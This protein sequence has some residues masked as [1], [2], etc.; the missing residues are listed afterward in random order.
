MAI[1]KVTASSAN[2]AKNSFLFQL[3]GIVNQLVEY[4]SGDGM[5]TTAGL[6][7]DSTPEDVETNNAIFYRIG[8]EVYTAA[9]NGG[10]SFTAAHVVTAEKFGAIL[11]QID[12]A[13]SFSTKV[14]E[15]TQT[16]AMAYDTA[17]EA[18]A[19]LPAPDEGNVAVGHIVIEADSGNWVGN[20]DSMTD[21][22]E[23]ATFV[24]YVLSA[25][26]TI[27][28]RELGTPS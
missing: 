7:V 18:V 22:L 25:P 15:A 1:R 28:T 27:T 12:A 23:A 13:G 20:T 11:V 8:G 21:D 3:A 24:D 26:D 6:D 9:A 10:F 2:A 17:D 16:T 19:A 4:V 5:L 14:G